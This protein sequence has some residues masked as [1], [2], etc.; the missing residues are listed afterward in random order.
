MIITIIRGKLYVC[1][2]ESYAMFIPTPIVEVSGYDL[3]KAWSLFDY[4]KK[5]KL[6]REDFIQSAEHLGFTGNAEMLF[7]GLDREGLG[8]VW[9]A[10]FEYIPKVSRTARQRLRETEGA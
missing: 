9:R 1:M 7:K 5:N 8:W 10:D 2:Y 3:D 6:T 4:E